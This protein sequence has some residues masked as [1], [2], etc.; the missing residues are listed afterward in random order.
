ME[1]EV[2]AL[3]LLKHGHIVEFFFVEHIRNTA[4]LFLEYMEGV[5]KL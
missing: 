5:R 2:M 4:L 3:A 1:I